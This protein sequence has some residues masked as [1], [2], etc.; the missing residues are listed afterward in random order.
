MENLKTKLKFYKKKISYMLKDERNEMK[1][2]YHRVFKRE[3]NLDNPRNFNEKLHF[4][5]CYGNRERMAFFADKFKVREY[6]K[7][8]LGED[9]LIPLLEVYDKL[10]VKDL[11]ELPNEFVVKTNHGS[12]SNHIEIVKNKDK[13]DLN[14]IVRKM[15]KALCE[16]FGF[17]TNELYYQLIEPK[18]IVEKSLVVD[19]KIPKDYKIQC[20]NKSG[21]IRMF[22][23]VD[24]GRFGKHERNIYDENWNLLELKHNSSYDHISSVKEPENFELMKE[25][26]RKIAK[27]FDYIR[28]DFYEINKKIYF[29]EITQV[30]GGGLENLK[31]EKWEGIW[32]ELWELDYSNSDLDIKDNPLNRRK[33]V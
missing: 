27:N 12:G 30:H 28:V 23:Q 15:N 4:R 6:V 33:Q 25:L 29:G 17:A 13:V 19:G 18:V 3:L 7:E 31:P 5:K 21:D 26:A 2:K 24:N 11:E 32:G 22:I 8:V 16:K 9:Y 14:K 20:F 10:T 1:K